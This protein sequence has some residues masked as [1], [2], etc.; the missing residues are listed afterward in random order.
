MIFN[1]T[2]N[3]FIFYYAKNC[4]PK[5][6]TV[7]ICKKK[8]TIINKKEKTKNKKESGKNNKNGQNR[9]YNNTMTPRAPI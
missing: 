1:C 2:R 5:T 8:I 3:I 6:L 4:D 7:H 9:D